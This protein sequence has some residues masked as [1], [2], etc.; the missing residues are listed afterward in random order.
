MTN[1]IGELRINET[2]Y[3]FIKYQLRKNSQTY[4]L[5]HTSIE[6]VLSYRMQDYYLSGGRLDNPD[7]IVG[8]LDVFQN[9][10]YGSTVLIELCLEE[11]TS[12]KISSLKKGEIEKRAGVELYTA[13][14]NILKYVGGELFEASIT[15]E[16]LEL[17]LSTPSTRLNLAVKKLFSLLSSRSQIER[18]HTKFLDRSL[19]A[20]ENQ[21]FDL[22]WYTTTQYP[23]LTKP[24]KEYIAIH[25]IEQFDN[26][27]LPSFEKFIQ[28]ARDMRI[29]GQEG[30]CTI[31]FESTGLDA[32]SENADE[33][34][35]TVFL[36]MSWEDH[37]AFGLCIG[38]K[39]F[40]NIDNM[41]LAE[42]LTNMFSSDLL[43][44]REVTLPSGFKYKR[45][46]IKTTAHNMNIDIRFGMLFGADIWINYDSM[47]IGFNLDPFQ[48]QGNNGAKYRVK[49][50][51]GI[52]YPDL[53]DIG[54][55]G[56]FEK[57]GEISDIRVALMYGCADVDLVRLM[58]RDLLANLQTEDVV[59]YLGGNQV[60]MWKKY[61]EEYMNMVARNEYLG[62]RVN[63]EAGM[64]AY[65]EN[66]RILSIYKS[67]MDL[68]YSKIV[69]L[70]HFF[71]VVKAVKLTSKDDKVSISF[72]N[73][74]NV[75]I[76]DIDSWSGNFLLAALFDVMK[77][78]I[79]VFTKSKKKEQPSTDAEAIKLYLKEKRNFEE[80]SKTNHDPLVKFFRE[81]VE[82]KDDIIDPL[83]N[84]ILIS[85]KEFN[86]LKYPFFLFLQRTAPLVKQNSGDLKNF[87][88]M[89]KPYRFEHTQTN[90]IVT[91][92]VVSGLC[93]ISKQSKQ[94]YVPYT[95]NYNILNA[96]QAS[97]EIKI[98]WMLSRDN[99]II[100]PLTDP[101][102]DPHIEA[103]AEFFN[104]PAHLVD[105][106]KERGPIKSVNFGRIYLME[107]WKTCHKIF[108]G[109]MT[110]ENLATTAYLLELFDRARASVHVAL[111]QYREES[112]KPRKS[113]PW[114]RWFLG[115][116]DFEIDFEVKGKSVRK[117]F[118]ENE[119]DIPEGERVPLLWG[120]MQ[121]EFKWIQ[122]IKMREDDEFW[123]RD[124]QKRRAGNFAVQGFASTL[125]RII[126]QRF[127]RS[128]WARGWI[129]EKKIILHATVYDEILLSYHKD[130]DPIEL[131]VVLAE[132]F[133]VKYKYKDVYSP[134]FNIGINITN[135]WGDAK[136]DKYE[137]PIHLLNQYKR[138]F[139]DKALRSTSP[140]DYNSLN[141]ENHVNWFL[142][143]NQAYKLRRI[144]HELRL[145]NEDF[146]IWD[147]EKLSEK[148]T[149]YHVRLLLSELN[150]YL[151]KVKDWED[152]VE[153]LCSTLVPFILKYLLNEGDYTIIFYR[154][155]RIKMSYAIRDMKFATELEFLSLKPLNVVE[156]NIKIEQEVLENEL[157]FYNED[158]FS[159]T[160]SDEDFDLFSSYENPEI[161]ET[162]GRESL[163]YLA[164]DLL[165]RLGQTEKSVKKEG[166]FLPS[167]S[168]F[169]FKADKIFITITDNKSIQDKLR[170]VSKYN[171]TSTASYPVFLKGKGSF[172]QFVTRMTKEQL[173]QLDEELSR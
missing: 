121:N 2:V 167:F 53:E 34:C 20:L 150:D 26:I 21:G 110:R 51:S 173:K 159:E 92:R 8:M 37:K 161:R 133:I 146:S 38:M 170:S 126:Y 99:S 12:Q 114:I 136:D 96:D 143:N 166:S 129:Q 61:D 65:Q 32:W 90:S 50:H 58:T 140:I 147:I 160:G 107:V 28:Q 153:V 47:Q 76:L 60:D 59:G 120:Y 42:R 35:K 22:S 134:P 24:G 15:T 169:T 91:R 125:L 25:N 98:A 145:L 132:A 23:G 163:N 46:E 16:A 116:K 10:F 6:D 106:K 112:V 81:A 128:A 30:L 135:T 95:D 84:K 109:E 103:C 54:G 31:D 97:V 156:K 3:V 144:R 88:T 72:P 104:K 74:A 45:S 138:E 83:N 127:M 122:H 62:V 80:E 19:E 87:M 70:N 48:T 100:E 164:R 94:Y 118:F 63:K 5:L 36:G 17:T 93:T 52:V 68:Y 152:P 139:L 33:R 101:E 130:I 13:D 165:T 131:I 43:N 171:S 172:L 89:G 108:D 40:E 79:L 1:L 123:Y 77:Y 78:P 39:H 66:Q 157:S 117:G 115:L 18:K 75:E 86:S 137:I 56:V 141:R 149:N 11:I 162:I 27:V 29:V 49:Q 154:N 4:I 102:K 82:I 148:F 41:L 57:F 71:G 105:R 113:P 111:N 85:A 73:L 9:K 168:N 64:V 44:D 69:A 155:K 151:F 142:K 124:R 119:K 55:K 67:H 158:L 7:W 14:N